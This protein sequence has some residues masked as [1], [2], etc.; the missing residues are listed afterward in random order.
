M[1]HDL[2]RSGAPAEGEDL[3]EDLAAVVIAVGYHG[4][5]Q[6]AAVPEVLV[7]V[8]AAQSAAPGAPAASAPETPP[9]ATGPGDALAEALRRELGR[10]NDA[11]ES[12]REQLGKL[13]DALQ[14]LEDLADGKVQ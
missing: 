10:I 6:L 2:H 9:V 5:A 4:H 8:R 1:A 12:L 7:A 11:F 13:Q 14:G 3:L